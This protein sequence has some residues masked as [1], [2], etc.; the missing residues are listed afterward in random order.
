ML[1]YKNSKLILQS[2]L[3]IRGKITWESPSNIAIVKYWGKYGIQLPRN[4]SLS[5]TLQNSKSITCLSYEIKKSNISNIQLNVKVNGIENNEFQSRIV[6]YL[7]SIIE[8]YPFL[9]QLNLTLETENTFPHSTGIASSASGFSALALC[10]CTLEKNLF[11]IDDNENEF[12]KKASYLA[13]L[14]SG[15]ASRSIYPYA[16]EWG[17]LLDLPGSSDEYAIPLAETIHPVF[18]KI[19][20]DILIIDSEKKSVS[21][22]IGHQLMEN[23]PYSTP[24]YQQANQRLKGLLKTIQD[25]DVPAYGDIMEKEALNLHALMMASNP[26]FILL[27][28]NTLLAISKLQEF[29]KV[30]NTNIYFT[31]DAGP[32]L[33]IQY[34]PNDSLKAKSFIKE[35]LLPLCENRIVIEDNAGEGPKLL[36]NENNI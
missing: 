14:G 18:K 12:F 2:N 30:T 1:N 8:I 20:N 36:S 31:L 10:L 4:P 5:I 13:R 29:R 6:K 19:H 15:S 27:K 23:N 11:E 25:G 21:S 9:K 24:R 28:P 35:E 26:P 16:S 3:D 32:N 22:T 17:K 34:P 33:H 7:E